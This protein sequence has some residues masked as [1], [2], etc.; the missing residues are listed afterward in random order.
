MTT[1]ANDMSR[2]LAAFDEHST[3]VI[4]VDDAAS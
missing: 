3:L 2:C 1:R 4:V